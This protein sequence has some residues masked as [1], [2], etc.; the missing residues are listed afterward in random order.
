MSGPV[1]LLGL[2]YNQLTAQPDFRGT[3][4]P[5]R[6]VIVDQSYVNLENRGI[7]LVLPDNEMVGTVQLHVVGHDDFGGYPDPLPHGLSFD[8]SRADVL[9][10]LG[11]PD[12]HGEEADVFLLGRKPAWDAY[13][14]DGV[15]M[16]LEYVR[17]ELDPADEHLSRL[18][19]RCRLVGLSPRARPAHDEAARHPGRRLR[20]RTRAGSVV[21]ILA[22][23]GAVA[24]GAKGRP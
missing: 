7:S 13:H 5:P 10:R 12:E 22:R 19:R 9:A 15:R 3:A 23:S 4:V 16:H 20:R 8:M 2:R 21:Q 14:R 11:S 17:C 6:E 1:D 24:S 18:S